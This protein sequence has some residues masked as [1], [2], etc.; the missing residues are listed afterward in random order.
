[1]KEISKY[2]YFA[3]LLWLVQITITVVILN[4]NIYV[5]PI[6]EGWG[7]SNDPCFEFS[8]IM[9]P[10]FLALGHSGVVTNALRSRSPL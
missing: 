4:L 6:S 8:T 10:L 2:E 5:F 3:T 9:R 1:M 7:L